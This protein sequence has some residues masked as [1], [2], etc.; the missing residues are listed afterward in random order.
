MGNVRTNQQLGNL[1]RGLSLLL[2]SGIPLAEGVGL[3]AEGE[4]LPCRA[5]LQTV[6]RGLE[7]GLP[8]ADALALW[9][10]LPGF[11]IGMVRV[12]ENTGRTGEALEA[13]AA[14]FEE[15]SRTEK[16]L[17]S[18]LVYPGVLLALMLA[19][20]GVLL[21]RVL[22][23]FDRVY[24]SL[25]TGL[26]GA[27]A[28]LLRL[29]ELLERGLPWIL[30]A[31][32]LLTAGGML[33]LRAPAL[34]RRAAA[35]FGDIGIG[36]KFQNARFARA[37]AM[38]LGSGLPLDE[39]LELA[40]Q[41][42]EG[43]PGAQRRCRSCAEAVNRGDPLARAMAGARLLSPAQGRMLELGI[44][45]G[46]GDAVMER[47]ATELEEAAADGLESFIGGL[48]PAMVLGAAV[49]VGLILLAV[50]LPLAQILSAMG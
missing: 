3:L 9:D 21:T 2:R 48:E 10:A 18:A 5:S 25:G 1:L 36:R 4:P 13:L 6:A 42:L 50:M 23:I 17:R 40:G 19:V 27:A 44:R 47:I 11:A 45:S 26:T 24:A 32:A 8:L 29:G 46:T 30:G 15:R 34:K 20:V 14:H 28:G 31:V 16:L 12:G 49:L 22:P 33:L 38:G 41:L 43:V 39:A 7:E 37:M 35:R